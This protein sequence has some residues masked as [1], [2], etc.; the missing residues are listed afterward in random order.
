MEI[1]AAVAAARRGPQAEEDGWA[2]RA[3]AEHP[4][5]RAE[6]PGTAV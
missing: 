3:G 5:R 1:A 4:V 2:Q 6:D